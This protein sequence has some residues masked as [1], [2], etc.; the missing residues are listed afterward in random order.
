MKLPNQRKSADLHATDNTNHLGKNEIVARRYAEVVFGR[1]HFYAPRAVKKNARAFEKWKEVTKLY[2]EAGLVFVSSSDIGALA[3]YCILYAE[4]EGLADRRLELEQ[5]APE[6]PAM[7]RELLMTAD[8][9]D[10]ARANRVFSLL[11][12]VT[13]MQGIVTLDR[14]INS[15][16]EALLKLE[17]RL[18]LNPAAKVRTLPIKR[19]EKKKDEIEELGFNV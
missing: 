5:E 8:D 13:A 9:Y 14:S 1:F 10:R 7:P 16:A 18:F 15:K 6:L 19:K 17:D 4:Y 2:K 3:R 12:Y 11:D